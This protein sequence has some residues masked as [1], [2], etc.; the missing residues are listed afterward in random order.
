MLSRRA[1]DVAR[2]HQTSTKPLQTQ[3][4]GTSVRLPKVVLRERRPTLPPRGHAQI[5]PKLPRFKVPATSL[6]DRR[7]GV[8]FRA[9]ALVPVALA[10]VLAAA[11]RPAAA[12]LENAWTAA[13]A[14]GFTPSN[15]ALAHNILTVPSNGLK[16]LAEF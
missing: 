2:A 13:N 5:F 8:V 7:H 15:A 6:P 16:G 4:V 3:A 9:V 14:P 10:L 12:T 11:P 1:A